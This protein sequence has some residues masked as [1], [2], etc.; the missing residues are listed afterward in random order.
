MDDSDQCQQCPK[1]SYNPE[2]GAT[3]C[4]PCPPGMSTDAVGSHN[5]TQCK[6]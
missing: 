1:G 2:G 6:G 4:V 5:I 3:D